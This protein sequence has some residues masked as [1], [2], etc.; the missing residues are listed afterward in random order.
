MDSLNRAN[1]DTIDSRVF[2]D[3]DVIYYDSIIYYDIISSN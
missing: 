3:D 2:L 1:H